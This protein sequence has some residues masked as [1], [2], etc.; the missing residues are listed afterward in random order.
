V[1][2][3]QGKSIGRTRSLPDA[4][5][6]LRA[7]DPVQYSIIRVSSKKRNGD[8]IVEQQ[9]IIIDALIDGKEMDPQEA[10][11]ALLSVT[12]ADYEVIELNEAVGSN[13]RHAVRVNLQTI[14][15]GVATSYGSIKDNVDTSVDLSSEKHQSQA[16]VVRLLLFILL[17]IIFVAVV[18]SLA[19]SFGP[20]HESNQTGQAPVE[21]PTAKVDVA[22]PAAKPSGNT[23]GSQ[24]ESA[25]SVD[26]PGM[27]QKQFDALNREMKSAERL[28]SKGKIDDAITAY[29]QIIVDHP[30]Y[31]RPRMAIIRDWM[32]KGDIKKAVYYC[33]EGQKKAKLPSDYRY[34]TQLLA[35]L[36]PLL[37]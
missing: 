24:M 22:S 28:E 11:L 35:K 2:A 10:L 18:V 33:Q 31:A 23:S 21:G 32:L 19:T 29:A 8:L 14:G 34:F 16:R 1:S 25:A 6:L 5:A 36:S 30:R 15:R 9:K 12:D 4:I 37:P 27:S 7:Q 13:V 20:S 17:P 3:S 26:D